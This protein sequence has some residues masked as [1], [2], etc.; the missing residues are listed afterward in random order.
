MPETVVVWHHPGGERKSLPIR[1]EG[2]GA[3]FKLA[4]DVIEAN[5]VACLDPVARDF[6]EIAAAVFAADSFATRGG[7]TRTEFGAAW[8]RR[9]DI[10]IAVDQLEL[11][12]SPAICDALADAAE[13]LT[14]DRFSFRFVRARRSRSA[15]EF[16][17]FADGPGAFQADEVVLFSGGLDSFA[18][19]VESL[20]AGKRI[21]LMTHRSAQKC[22]PYQ[23]RLGAYLCQRY[24]RA[25]QHV[26]VRATRLETPA[27][28]R[29]QRSRSFLFAALA[30]A[31]ARLSGAR[32][33]RFF[34]NGVVSHNLPISPQVIGTMATRT[35]H[36]GTILRL[37][38]I[39]DLVARTLGEERIELDNPYAW[40]TK[41]EV[42]RRIEHHGAAAQ[43][44]HSV[45]C[46][47]VFGRKRE[48]THCGECSQCLDRRFAV[49]AGG[50]ERWDPSERYG[51]DVFLDERD[52]EVARTLAFDWAR[53]ALSLTDTSR[54][55]LLMRFASELGRA[56]D[57]HPE[58]AS[59]DYYSR[60]FDLHRRHGQCARAAFE[61]M[62]GRH[63][64]ALSSGTLPEQALLRQVVEAK[65]AGARVPRLEKQR[66]ARKPGAGGVEPAPALTVQNY[67]VAF[68]TEGDRHRVDVIGL[69]TVDGAPARVAHG[70]KV[71]YDEDRAE[72]RRIE[73]HRYVHSGKIDP[74]SDASK[75]SV[76]SAVK[77]FRD[78]L[79]RAYAA[80]EGKQPRDPLII[81]T[82]KGEGYRLDPTIIVVAPP[83]RREG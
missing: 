61:I 80:I 2:P 12:T 36:P 68:D 70:L 57:G 32:R 42:L 59:K 5:A 24:G 83:D 56:R 47:R 41:L 31:A 45:S 51:T 74:R 66:I 6:L 26:Q 79:S 50:L 71:F 63:L 15:T 8:R 22:I 58:L 72:R 62:A 35:T 53:H 7:D 46:A 77:R 37:A 43:I 55:E 44:Q 21:A 76:I 11:W 33:I 29:T 17:N 52:S 49:V 25:V 1:F 40:L 54:E 75:R 10:T 81:Q 34:E 16:F 39:L 73:E 78:E 13:F 18:G 14:D 30:F 3:T 9:F 65:A 27:R 23:K 82:K 4:T 28:E 48:P 64:N 69:A 19:A 60:A 20:A 67:Q 38:R